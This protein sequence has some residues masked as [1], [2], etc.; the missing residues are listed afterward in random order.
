MPAVTLGILTEVLGVCASTKDFFSRPPQTENGP[1]TIQ[2]E[3]AASGEK[4]DVLHPE[5]LPDP[6][7]VLSLISICSTKLLRAEQSGQQL[8]NLPP[9]THQETQI[10]LD[11]AAWSN[12]TTFGSPLLPASVHE[13]LQRSMHDALIDIMAERDATNAQLI[14]TSQLHSH[15]LEHEKRK[16]RLLELELEVLRRF[17]QTNQPGGNLFGGQLA[18]NT[19]QK[20]LE[21]KVKKLQMENSDDMM[22][23]LSQQLGVEIHEKTEL[24]AEINRMKESDKLKCEN[25]TS[26]NEALKKEL[27][28]VKDLLAAEERSKQSAVKE[29]EGWKASY[30]RLK[31]ESG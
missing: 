6:E 16:N 3:P 18:G 9:K 10:L 29:A 14:A 25:E 30:E 2:D 26:E 12:Y 15:E 19:P 28:R 4:M 21:A 11:P 17:S 1:E 13:E 8:P 20:D 31:A 22:V 24:Q 27:K 7:K 5:S 23:A